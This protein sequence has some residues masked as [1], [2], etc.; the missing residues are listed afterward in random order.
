[1][2]F[3]IDAHA[4]QLLGNYRV[5]RLLGQGEFAAVYLAEHVR[6]KTLVAIKVLQA[7]LRGNEPEVFLEEARTLAFL[8]HPHIVR[9]LDF[10]VEKE[11]PFLVID[12]APDGTLRQLHPA[13]TRLPLT[14]VVRYIKQIAAALQYAHEHQVIHRD[15]KPDNMLVSQHNQ[16]LLSDFG[17]AVVSPPTEHA[18]GGEVGSSAYAAPEQLL[19]RPCPASD[20]YALGIVAYE[21]LAGARPF[22]GAALEMLVQHQSRQPPPLQAQNPDVSAAIEAVVLRALAKDPAARWPSVTAFTDAL[23]R[24]LRQ[25]PGAPRAGRLVVARTAARQPGTQPV[26][27]VPYPRN[28][29]FTGRDEV[30]NHLHRALRSAEVAALTQPRAISGLG[31]IGKTATAVEYAYRYRDAYQDVLWA[32]AETGETLLSDFVA[33]AAQLDL[34]EKDEQDSNLVAAA[35]KQWL[36]GQAGWLLVLDNVEEV[37][38]LADFLPAHGQGSVLLTTRSPVTAAGAFRID[39][40]EMYPEEGAL[41]LL[42]RAGLV[43]ADVAYG[44]IDPPSLRMEAREVAELL[45]GLPLALDQAGAYIEE[46]GCTLFGYL[47]LYRTRRAELLSRRGDLYPTGHPEPVATTWSLSFE[48]IER[49]NPAAAALLRF[50]AFAAPDAIPEEVIREGAVELGP[51]GSRVAAEQMELDEALRELRKFSLVRRD[52]ATRVLSIHRLVQAVLRDTMDEQEQQRWIERVVRAVNRAFPDGEDV[53]RWPQCER[54]LAQVHACAALLEERVLVMPEGARL[55]NQAGLYHL[56]HAQYSLAELFLQRALAMRMLLVEGRAIGVGEA[57]LAESLNDL[58]AAYASQGRYAEAEP[59]LQRA[60]DLH[61]RALGPL[62]PMVAT[63]TN[64]VAMLCYYQKKYEQAEPLFLRALAIWEQVKVPEHPDL[65]RTTSNLALLY[66]VQGRFA[67]AEPLYQRALAIWERIVGPEHPDVAR[68][69]NNLARLYRDQGRYAEA[70]PLFLRA[71]GIR[72]RT[73]GPD[74]PHVAQTLGDL[75]KLYAEMGREAEAEALFLL[76]LDIREQLLG[77]SHPSMVEVLENYAALLRKAG[78]AEEAE[79][80]AGRARSIQRGT[81]G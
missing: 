64:N 2:S 70:E 13:G 12:Y 44:A 81:S 67:Q 58:G 3:Y 43:E 31:G 56:E 40:D 59:L 18:R 39:L 1:M 28:P 14:P 55:L 41:F 22:S 6:L 57:D 9:V 76:A 10:G 45:D 78:R 63:A 61:E 47:D 69:L 37:A 27:H 20:Q 36:S 26:W 30:L 7:A 32:R 38:L 52:L 65:A 51:T 68:T 25:T 46:T 16:V 80:L 29:F 72:E 53:S 23:E 19:G 73:L 15:V 33:F 24:A 74:H 79:K 17:I 50:C 34:P 11:T 54:C 42:R 8:R 48:R 77:P 66:S 71:R 35:V 5:L 60:L 75:G 49:Q 62:H 4:P 21:W